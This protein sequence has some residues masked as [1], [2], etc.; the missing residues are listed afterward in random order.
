[1]RYIVLATLL[2]VAP[3]ALAAEGI[4]P[5]ATTAAKAADVKAHM[6]VWDKNGARAGVV[7]N[8]SPA[9]DGTIESVTVIQGENSGRIP[10]ATLSM[11]NGKLVT[12]LG[13]REIAVR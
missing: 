10:G 2:L 11:A 7:I 9:A 4:A 1:M 5:V 6:V 13:R 3:A 12:S 8:V